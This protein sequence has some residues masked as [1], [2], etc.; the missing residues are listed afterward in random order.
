MS[1]EYLSDKTMVITG[2]AG[3]FGQLLCRDAI[4][5]GAKVAALDI[6]APALDALATDL[7]V[8]DALITIATDVTDLAAMTAAVAQAVAALAALTS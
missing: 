5:R 3:G 7:D 1:R 6:N 8:G 2:A 4:A